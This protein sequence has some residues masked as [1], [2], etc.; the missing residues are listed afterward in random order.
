MKKIYLDHAATTPV[1]PDVVAAML[2]YFSDLYG[3][4]SSAHSWGHEARQ[5]VERARAA[6]AAALG[7]HPHEIVFTGSGTE[8]NNAAIKGIA[9]A[10]RRRG[11]HLITSAIEHRAVIEPCRFLENNG[12]TVTYLPVDGSGLVSPAEV[13]KAITPR[14]ILISIMHANNE[15]GTMQP[16]AEIGGI[17]REAGICF[18]T[19]AVQTFGHVPFRVDDLSADLLSVSAHKLYGPKGVG[20]LYIR[21]GMNV[22]PLLHGG[23]QEKGRRSSTHNVPGIVGLGRAA[24]IAT[25]EARAEAARLAALRD[26]MIREVA[27]R[28]G[29]SALNG[30]PSLRLPGNAH[31]SFENAE[32]DLL[33]HYL[34][35]R[36]V[37]CSTGSACS[38]ESEG[39]SPVLLALGLPDHLITGSLRFSLGRSTTEDDIDAVLDMLVDVV[40][41]VRSL[42]PFR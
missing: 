5:A 11:D 8:S 35:Q 15:I 30:H 26:R 17:A 7:A 27:E 25:A 31:F 23:A 39:P 29:G 33:M 41:E 36:G 21:E 42:S 40:K 9:F 14:T 10:N 1:H 37:A 12:F 32:G 22:E 6:V 28:I 4:P 18:H 13:R 16:V 3:N 20:A 24:E 34:D 19:D 2:P 38:A